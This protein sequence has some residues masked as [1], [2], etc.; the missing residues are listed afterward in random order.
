MKKILT[1]LTILFAF[2]PFCTAAEQKIHIG[3]EIV[4]RTACDI[5]SN[6]PDE[7]TPGM[8]WKAVSDD[9]S[10][11][12][13]KGE[14]SLQNIKDLQR[15]VEQIYVVIGRGIE[16][17]AAATAFFKGEDIKNVRLNLGVFETLLTKLR[18]DA[19]KSERITK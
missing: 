16:T 11:S 5:L 4:V 3:R 2:T 7:V 19:E 17:S 14:K 15:S 13:S 9:I 1:I 10:M 8:V 12:I 6:R 18:K